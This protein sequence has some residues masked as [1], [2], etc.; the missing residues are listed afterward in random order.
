MTESQ[1]H[2]LSEGTAAS[3][4][5]FAVNLSA[6]DLICV[7]VLKAVDVDTHHSLHKG[8]FKTLLMYQPIGIR[9]LQAKYLSH[10]HHRHRCLILGIHT[11]FS[12]LITGTAG[13]I[14]E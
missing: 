8:R 11:D 14:R 4:T 5:S 7:P 13:L 12:S 3:E 2:P 9:F 1:Y 10:F 6:L